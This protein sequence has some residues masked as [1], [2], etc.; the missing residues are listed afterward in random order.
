MNKELVLNFVT[1]NKKVL[2]LAGLGIVIVGGGVLAFR[3]IKKLA[4]ADLVR[5]MK[6]MD[7]DFHDLIN[8]SDEEFNEE[9]AKKRDDSLNKQHMEAAKSIRSDEIVQKMHENAKRKEERKVAEN[10]RKMAEKKTAEK[11]VYEPGEQ[12]GTVEEYENW[13]NQR[14]PMIP[15][16]DEIVN[17]RQEDFGFIIKNPENEDDFIVDDRLIYLPKASEARLEAGEVSQEQYDFSKDLWEKSKVSKASKKGGKKH[18][19]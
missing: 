13:L 4:E 8:S 1:A 10:L 12:P 9:F 14:E 6:G 2:I 3:R 18:V 5:M 7:M 19:S 16:L 11:E 15:S 17:P